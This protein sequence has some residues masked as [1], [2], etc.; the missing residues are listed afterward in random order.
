MQV[1]FYSLQSVQAKINTDLLH[2]LSS[3]IDRK[4]FILGKEVSDF[5]NEFAQYCQTQYCIG[6]ANG[7][8]ALKI[9]LRSLAIGKGDEVIV[10]ANTYIATVLAVLEVGAIPVLVEPDK[11]TYNISAENI[12]PAINAKTKAIIPVHLFGQP[13]NMDAIGKLAKQHTLYIIEDNAQAQGAGF[14]KQPA[15]SFGQINATSFYPSKNLG[16]M[17]DAGGITTNDNEL[18]GKARMLRNVGSSV[19]YHHQLEGYNSRL[20]T[21]QAAVLSCKLPYLNEWNTDRKRI[22]ARYLNN[23]KDEKNIVLPGLIEGAEHVYH[24]F[25]IR[26]KQRDELQ[27]YLSG[28]HIQTLIHYP[29]PNHLQLALAH[30]GYKKGDLPITEEL[31]DT[32]LSLPLFIDIT[33]AQIDYVSDKI[34]SFNKQSLN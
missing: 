29:I 24:L 18:A 4:D 10:P 25:V 8:D 27:Q 34:I 16:A 15:G 3:V 12:A 22:A 19:K 26:H 7:L 30:L 17:G 20:D 23:L 33:D 21:L 6:V 31:A 9:C 5:E 32:S 11:H 28:Q 13:C 14:N 1:P 2:R